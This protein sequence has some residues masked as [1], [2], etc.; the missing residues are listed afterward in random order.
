MIID[1]EEQLEDFLSEPS[2]A[3]R[4]ALA[5][6]DGDLIILGAA[7]KMG[8]SL[9]R[10]ARRAAP[11]KNVFA[12]AR[13]PIPGIETLSAD[14][15][16][17]TQ[18]DR[19]PDAPNV[20]FM[21]GRKFGSV[22][23]EPLTW[24]TNTLLPALVA[25]RFSRSRIVAFSTGNVYPFVP[26]A[27]D[28]ATEEVLPNPVG[29]YA[30][31]ALGRERMFEYF[32]AKNGTPVAILRL[33]YAVELRYGVLVDIARQVF[34]H[35]PIGLSMGHVN[36][37]WQGDANSACLRSFELCESPPCI[38]NLTGP[39]TLSVRDVATRF[40]RRFGI[41][42]QFEGVEAQTALLSNASRLHA[43]LGPPTTAVDTMIEMIA[44]WIQSARPAWNKPTHFE[45]R[46]GRF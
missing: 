21:C 30:Q 42:P 37:I 44:H 15:L 9:V 38:L 18:L 2:D 29:E 5:Q 32:S 3:D 11:T 12:V 36:V 28:G 39:E 16:D 14:L 7:G 43:L 46:S 26:V 4:A 40:G 23:N 22:G 1:T 13:S 35:R 19:L 6:L 34:E 17:R 20:I 45:S 24:A 10:R 25:D 31:S 41:E 27:S 8:P 33:N